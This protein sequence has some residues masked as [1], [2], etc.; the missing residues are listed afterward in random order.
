MLE[1]FQDKFQIGL[2][3]GACRVCRSVGDVLSIDSAVRGGREGSTQR[4][5]QSTLNRDGVGRSSLLIMINQCTTTRV[6]RFWGQKQES[7]NQ[8]AVAGIG[9]PEQEIWSHGQGMWTLTVESELLNEERGAESPFCRCCALHRG[10]PAN[11]GC[12]GVR[13]ASQGV[14]PLAEPLSDDHFSS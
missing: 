1:G 14:S 11:Q 3:V 5:D 9:T 13:R 6:S 4:S 2:L 12:R 8:D 10:R 7:L